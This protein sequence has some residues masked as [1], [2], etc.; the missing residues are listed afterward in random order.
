[1]SS[2]AFSP[3]SLSNSKRCL[4]IRNNKV[5]D[6]T[7]FL[8]DHPGGAD[9]IENYRGKDVSSIMTDE[10]SHDHSESAYEML[11]EFVV[12][13]VLKSKQS[14]SVAGSDTTL[15]DDVSENKE[16]YATGMT[17]EDDL[18]VPTDIKSDYDKH[19][20]LD[21]G[22]PLLPQVFNGGFTKEFYLAQVHRPRHYPHGSAPLMPFAWMEPFS[23]TPWW[24]VPLMWFPG[25]I[26]GTYL[27]KQGLST[28]YQL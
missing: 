22:K 2:L 27:A 19:R 4:V 10:I 7:D 23:K 3:K 9:L 13:F 24:I 6:V 25:V 21:L 1:M 20:F 26:Y 11:E 15:V 17:C 14:P 16:I 28:T 18:N 12:G 8:P 5:Y